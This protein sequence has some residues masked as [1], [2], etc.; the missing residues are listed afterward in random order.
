[1][2]TYVDLHFPVL[3]RKL[4]SASF[5]NVGKEDFRESLGQLYSR[6]G[7]SSR[8]LPH[9]ENRESLPLL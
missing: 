8:R 9:S 3:N 1:M 6:A 2:G 5:E 4:L 7:L